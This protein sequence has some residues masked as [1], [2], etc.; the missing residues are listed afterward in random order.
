MISSEECFSAWAPDGAAWTEWAKPVVFSTPSGML[1][2]DAPAPPPAVVPPD[3]GDASS[4]AA[5]IVDVPGDEAV[6]LGLLL[7]AKGFRPVPLFNG[8]QGPSPV[9]DLEPMVKGL[10][11]GAA[12]L[13]QLTLAPDAPPAFL[14]DA[15]RGLDAGRVQPGSYD[16]RWVVLPQDFPSAAFLASKGIRQVTLILRGATSPPVDLSHVL[17]RWQQAGL[18]IRVADLATGR[19]DDNV[20][21]REPN[22]FRRACYAA[23]AI[24]RLRRS[25]IGGFGSAVPQQTAGHG[26]FG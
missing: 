16:N 4:G 22:W 1:P 8:T 13:R 2:I 10:G 17:L 21:V 5:V 19:V 6:E 18:R 9:I 14:L 3:V 20:R 24:M 11:A 15:R 26:A 23:L 12:R 25:N 7:A